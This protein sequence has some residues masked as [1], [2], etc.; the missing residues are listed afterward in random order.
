V[1]TDLLE[2]ARTLSARSEPYVLATVV[3]RRAPS[4]GQV[5]SRAVITAD[6]HVTGWLGGA[7]A[8]PAVIS[9]A[10]RALEQG[11]PRLMFLGTPEELAE[12]RRD[13]V[14]SVPIACQSEGALE[15][16]VEPVFPKPQVVAIGRSPAVDSLAGMAAALGWRSAVVDD[17]GSATDHPGI[18]QVFT[19]LDLGAAGVDEGSFVVVATQGHYD[20]DALL[21]A[22]GTRARYVGLVAS[23]KRAAAVM[24]YLR[25]R[26][27]EEGQLQR[28]HAPAGVDLGHV[29]P[30]EIAVAIMAELVRLKAAGDLGPRLEMAPPSEMH[31]AIDPVCGMTVQ[32]ATARYLATHGGRTYYF[33]S[34]GCQGRFEGDPAR[35]AAAAGTP[36]RSSTCET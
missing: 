16:Y 19:A 11:T 26:G 5:G 29:A 2:L 13:G 25:D 6:G 34:A 12:H 31:E 24:G 17:G 1:G 18:E 14:V 3:W 36:D 15:V 35:F 7:C 32:V 30:E 8:E 22:L 23:R 4:S 21:A 33:C 10:R 28:V 27:V 9:E 20:E